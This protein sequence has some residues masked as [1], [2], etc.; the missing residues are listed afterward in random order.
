VWKLSVDLSRVLVP[1]MGQHDPL[2]GFVTCVQLGRTA[3]D[4]GDAPDV[5][6]SAARS[7][8]AGMVDHASRLVTDDPLGIGG[9]LVDAARLHQLSMRPDLVASL[10]SAA[11]IGIGQWLEGA[12]LHAPAEHRLAF[13]ELGLAIGIAATSLLDGMR[14]RADLLPL[15][16]EIESFWLDPRHRDSA[17]W[18]SH[19][20]I[21]DVMLAT[22]LEPL[23]FL[24]L[25]RPPARG[26]EASAGR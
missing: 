25:P 4:L 26:I 19:A 11:T 16:E 20:D 23:G 7:D 22:A 8:Y 2:D 5:R 6:L 10:A 9:L 24:V 18:R 1:S 13:R 3:F 15:R 14:D 12:D 17:T 21:N